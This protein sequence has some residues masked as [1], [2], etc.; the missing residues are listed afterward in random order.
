MITPLGERQSQALDVLT[1]LV[2]HSS[3]K[4]MERELI[5]R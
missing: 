2:L 1:Q 4:T 3:S 5:T